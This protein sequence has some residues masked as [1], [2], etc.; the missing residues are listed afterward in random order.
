MTRL[1]TITTLYLSI[2]G[3]NPN[4]SDLDV[5]T[6]LNDTVPLETI[7]STM[8]KQPSALALPSSSEAFVKASFQTLFD[9]TSQEIETIIEEQAAIATSGGTDG[10]QYW[11]NELDDNPMITKETLYVALI[12]GSSTEDQAILTAKVAD[13]VFEYEALNQIDTEGAIQGT[14]ESDT[15]SATAQDDTILALGGND[16]ITTFDGVDTVYAGLGDDIIYG[17]T[18]IDALYAEEGGDTIYADDGDDVLDGGDGNDYI[19]GEVG[20]DTINGGDGDDYIYGGDGDDTIKAGKG[21]DTV[22]GDAGNNSIYGEAGNDTIF[23]GEGENFVDGGE[24]NDTIYGNL[25]SD[26]IYGGFGNDTIYGDAEA[27]NLFG[28]SGDDTI[29]G[30]DGDDLLSGSDGNDTLYGSSGADTLQGEAGIDRLVGGLG[31]D[32]LVGGAG[33]DTFVFSSLQSTATSMDT[34]MDFD[35]AEDT[36]ELVNQGNEQE[37]SKLD[38]GSLT[39]LTEALNLASAEDGSTDS[40][41]NWFEFQESTYIVQDLSANTTFDETEDLVIQIQGILNIENINITYI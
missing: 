29:Y 12:N 27:D 15:I 38:I 11:V 30:G 31:A 10:F 41:I 9:Y 13:I 5:Y 23:L 35:I 4:S 25:S 36:L 20:N 8:L 34:I 37:N 22:Q 16:T 14:Q 6:A 26:T 19:Y 28:M 18:G 21:N 33:Q 32:T 3:T 40:I 17:G 7:A 39:T 2:F 1:E 24:D